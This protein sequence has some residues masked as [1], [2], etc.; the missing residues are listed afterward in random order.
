M[1][2]LKMSLAASVLIVAIVLVRALTL[3]KLPKKAFLALWAV[4][5]L[6]LMIPFSLPSR[7]SVFTGIDA[8]EA[9]FAASPALSVPE[10]TVRILPSA[11]ADAAELAA[12]FVR[13]SLVEIVWLIGLCVFA[14]FFLVSYIKCRREFKSSQPLASD[15]V[16]RWQA[17]NPLR[18]TVQVRHSDRVKTPLTYGIF[19]PV[20]LL[21]A[22]TDLSHDER[23]RYILTHEY[24]HI[25]RC[26]TLTKLLLTALVCVHWFNPL[27]W[28]MYVLANRDIE[29]SCDETVV[30]TM[31]EN[32]RSTYAMMLIEL[33]ESKC[34]FSPLV[35]NFSK[36][37]IEERIVSIM[38]TRRITALAVVVAVLVVVG[39][40]TVFATSA[41]PQT[42]EPADSQEGQ[43]SITGASVVPSATDFGT[44]MDVGLAENGL[45]LVGRE[46][47]DKGDEIVMRISS[48]EEM[49]LRVG[50]APAE[51]IEQ[52]WGYNDYGAA[53][54]KKADVSA[55]TREVSFTVPESGE[56]G[57]VVRHIRSAESAAPL[58]PKT[59][60]S[61]KLSDGKYAIDASDYKTVLFKLEIN[62]E[63]LNP[64]TE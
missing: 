60:E 19:R 56:Y 20:I 55:Q 49:Q 34:Q 32:I 4:A 53:I 43:I 2:I 7:L 26:D 39:L 46:T 14:V 51:D 62:K 13:V 3:N 42:P 61:D 8:L 37:A 40:T 36:C 10:G 57:I 59:L 50:I 63:F 6:R 9:V 44:Q 45:L 29:L 64:L 17:E 28:V 21:P 48:E 5:A 12:P 23:L 33:E 52:G 31:G 18:R 24:V 54:E 27:V 1:D 38:K 41:V 22:N 25:R 58:P 11:A 15:F 35:T 30:R 16:S 47:W